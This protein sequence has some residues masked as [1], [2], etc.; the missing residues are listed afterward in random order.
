MERRRF[1]RL[2]VLLPVRYSA[3]PAECGELYQGQGLTRD[4]SL[5]GSYFHVSS[6]G[7]IKPGCVISLNIDASLPFPDSPETSHFQAKGE[8]VRLELPGPA[9]PYYGVA[10]NFLEGPSFSPS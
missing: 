4:I 2:N 1:V 9:S 8:V 7:P 10:V 5:S 6:P 3:S